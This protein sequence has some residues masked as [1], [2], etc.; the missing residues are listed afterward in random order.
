[1]P[2]SPL[3]EV[4]PGLAG[5]AFRTTSPPD[6][7]YNCVAWAAGDTTKW[8]EPDPWEEYYWPP[9][10][11]RKYTVQ[12]YQAAFESLGYA[13]SPDGARDDNRERI[14]IFLKEGIPRHVSRRLADRTWTSKLGQNID[15]SHELNALCG[16]LYGSVDSI[17]CRPAAA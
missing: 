16:D 5:T 10:A 12:A 11:P 17:M 14:A 6:P 4:F 13:L 15:I 1:M 2:S 3:D 8:W 7:G 9:S